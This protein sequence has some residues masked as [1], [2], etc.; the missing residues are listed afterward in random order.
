MKE[1]DLMKK[2]KKG[3]DILNAMRIMDLENHLKKSDKKDKIDGS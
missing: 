3:L 1:P 2:L